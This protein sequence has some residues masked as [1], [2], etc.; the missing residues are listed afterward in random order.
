MIDFEYK[1][2]FKNIT[3]AID[4]SIKFDQNSIQGYIYPFWDKLGQI[5]SKIT[6][7]RS[8]N[9]NL[10]FLGQ[11]ISSWGT[12]KFII[13]PQIKKMEYPGFFQQF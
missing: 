4:L 7:L 13:K 8:R 3:I 9:E 1:T 11:N 2:K 6:Q 12:A 10:I 5:W